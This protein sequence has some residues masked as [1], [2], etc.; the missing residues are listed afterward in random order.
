MSNIKLFKDF[1]SESTMSPKDAKKLSI[2]SKIKTKNDTYTITGFGAKTGATREFET[3]NE[4]GKKFNVK[5]S[6]NGSQ[7]VWTAAAP[8]LNYDEKGEVLESFINEAS[9]SVVQ[10]HLMGMAYA[11][12][13]GELKSDEVS[14]EVKDLADSMTMQDLKDFASTKH[15][16]LPQKVKENITA[17]NITGMG[18][19]SFPT[20]DTNGSGDVPAGQGD[21]KKEYKKKK[22]KPTVHLTFESFVNEAYEDD[23]INMM[24]GYFGSMEDNYDAKTAHKEFDQAVQDLI[25]EFKFKEN[26]ALNL[27]NSK[28][29]RQ[30]ADAI[31]SG[32]CEKGAVNGVYWYL[33][34]DKNKVI[35]YTKKL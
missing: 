27:L 5:V 20:G 6:L 13:K 35:S 26:E 29:G 34:K 19:V 24:Y 8:S 21:A 7:S 30:A 33:G 14:S 3:E 32:E 18:P 9:K 1:L 4:E 10:Q 11:Y 28:V 15:K 25:K 16:G 31:I 2:G 12:K 22:K 17:A 23:D